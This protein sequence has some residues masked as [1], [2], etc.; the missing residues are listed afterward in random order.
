MKVA[1][2]T[3]GLGMKLFRVKDIFK[4]DYKC[5][6][7]SDECQFCKSRKIF[8]LNVSK[9]L[10]EF[11]L[12]RQISQN[13]CK[14]KKVLLFGGLS[15]DVSSKA[16]IAVAKAAKEKGL[17]VEAFVVKPFNFEG[18]NRVERAGKTLQILKNMCDKVFVYE[19]ELLLE[20]KYSKI[21]VNEALKLVKESFAEFVWDLEKY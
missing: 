3:G 15:G 13:I 10:E 6:L 1:V 16:L 14:A 8:C 17:K 20:R 9:H 19:N 11:E 4:D 7:I 12:Y 18:K 5:L 21:S 2:G